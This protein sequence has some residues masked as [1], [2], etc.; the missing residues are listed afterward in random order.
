LVFT[1][2][3]V[4]QSVLAIQKTARRKI[5]EIGDQAMYVLNV[6]NASSSL[7]LKGL[8]VEDRPPLGFTYLA[9]STFRDS[10]RMADPLILRTPSGQV[11]R[12]SM[13]DSLGAGERISMSYRLIVGAG[14]VEGDG[15]NRVQAFAMES[16]GTAV[17]SAVA[18]ERVEVQAGVFTDRGVIIG[19]VF[20]DPNTN[21]H[22][23]PGE[24][25]VKGVELMLEDGTRIITGDDGK[26]SIPEVAPGRH[27]IKVRAHTLPAMSTLHAGYNDFAFDPSSRFVDVTPGG[28]ARA[29]F[30]LDQASFDSIALAHR[31]TRYGV[32][33]I[34]RFVS[35][36][37]VTFIDDERP[38]LMK[39]TGLNFEVGKAILR[40]EAYALI[41]QL[42]DI[43][44]EN[45]DERVVIMGHTDS[46]PIRTA[47]F[48]N[49]RVLSIARAEAV[50]IMLT[51]VEGIDISRIETRGYGESRPVAT[52]ATREGKALNRR[53]EFSFG[54]VKDSSAVRQDAAVMVR[55]PVRYHGDASIRAIEITDSLPA[56][57]TYADSSGIFNGRRIQ[58]RRDGQK[59]VWTIDS[60]GSSISGDLYYQVRIPRPAPGIVDHRSS[61]I[62]IRLLA[63]E[64]LAVATELP[65]V[66][67]AAV[68]VR[69]R[70]VNFIMPS[71]LFETAKAT[72]Q[73]G[74]VTSLEA[75]A[76]LL[77]NDPT[78]TVV[79]EGHTDSRPI[80]TKQFPSNMGLSQARAQTIVNVLVD[81]FGIARERMEPVG[82]GEHRPIETNSTAVGRQAN[83][84]IE[85]RVVRSEF[86]TAVLPEG[87]SD[88][89][90][91]ARSSV[92]PAP[93]A[94]SLSA[95]THLSPNDRVIVSV[96]TSWKGSGRRASN[97]TV[98]DSLAPWLEIVD[99]SLT[100]AGIDSIVSLK[101]VRVVVSPSDEHANVRFEARLLKPMTVQD[102]LKRSVSIMPNGAPSA[103]ATSQRKNGR[104]EASHK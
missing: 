66:N 46:S 61:T 39:L 84:R 76:A 25:G 32:V 7:A 71:V 36:K 90:Q 57:M 88:S 86:V 68:A 13:A 10:V 16:N 44:R 73:P 34:Q 98:V 48:P 92:A 80:R 42:A 85:I 3:D 55:I 50:K 78:L 74:A 49:N 40:T 23:D 91:V 53:V 51:K 20:F 75:T 96:E 104:T 47:E 100:T 52:N 70:A 94:P 77:K 43:L 18:E 37:N 82:F 67:R 99:G 41:R 8:V 30:Y 97:V 72:L 62:G 93:G 60:V 83:R 101:P 63:A 28:I 1:Q 5:V 64:T 17:A 103:S 12:W 9:G 2:T 24:S 29:D 89:T 87:G 56:S 21:A 19:K 35:P 26:Y 54:P 95:A 14:A 4:I 79:V 15:I 11:L 38:A 59:L 65:T 81:M 45:P 102:I 22:Q 69:G 58:P 33:N 6:R 31:V 27:V